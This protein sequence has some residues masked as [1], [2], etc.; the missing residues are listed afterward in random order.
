MAKSK[1]PRKAKPQ[2]A[3]RLE[4]EVR[5]L[6]GEHKLIYDE[7]QV[8][9]GKHQQVVG[10][11]EDLIEK[12]KDLMTEEEK[13]EG[14]QLV[15]TFKQ[16]NEAYLNRAK[17]V[18]DTFTEVVD[19][20]LETKNEGLILE[21]ITSTVEYGTI[22]EEIQNTLVNMG[23]TFNQFANKINS[24]L[25]QEEGVTTSSNENKPEEVTN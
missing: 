1:S 20:A 2:K 5:R 15:D 23:E 22:G 3:S 16:D 9:I 8:M 17:T 18:S 24:R 13:Q 7:T 19:R 10:E 25:D 14:Q 12:G 4:K 21:A 11:L 6:S